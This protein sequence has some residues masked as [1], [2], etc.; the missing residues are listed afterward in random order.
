M[1]EVVYI[2]AIKCPIDNA[3]IYVGKSKCPARRLRNH[4]GRNNSNAPIA[5]YIRDLRKMGLMP[6]MKII[7]RVK[8]ENIGYNRH[9]PGQEREIYWI[10]KY[11]RSRK[12]RV[13]NVN[14]IY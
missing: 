10:N 8:Y 2:Y 13:L 14:S 3:I 6:T 12:H 4:T 5:E 11:V 1:F 7:E 9:N